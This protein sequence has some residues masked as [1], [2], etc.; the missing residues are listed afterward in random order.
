M[1]K[2]YIWSLTNRITH[3]LLIILFASTYISADKDYLKYHTTFAVLFGCVI[4]FRILW[5]Y[6]GPKYSRFKD[7]NFNKKELKEYLLS[8]FKIVKKHIGH[9]PASSWAIVIIFILGIL[10]IITGMLAY[11]TEHQHG[12]F[13]FLYSD[14]LKDLKL[15]RQIH[16]IIV[17]LLM[18][19]ILAHIAGALIDKY[20]KKNDSINSMIDGYK[21]TEEEV[22]VKTNVF[23]KTISIVAVFIFL[24]IIIYL[25]FINNI[26]IS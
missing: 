11:G 1:Y 14:Y 2:S 24:T 7:F 26:F 19:T 17:H 25:V 13:A 16:E 22:I 3:I 15:F 4:L 5:G 10:A 20:I 23:Q 9:N 21:T 8:P 12:I 18:L 6:I